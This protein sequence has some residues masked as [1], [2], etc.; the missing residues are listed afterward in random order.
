MSMFSQPIAGPSPAQRRVTAPS[1]PG[2]VPLPDVPGEALELDLAAMSAD[3]EQQIK[4]HEAKLEEAEARM[5]EFKIRNLD[6]QSS[7]GKD[8]MGRVVDAAKQLE[9][10]KLELREAENAR[11]MAKAQISASLQPAPQANNAP[12]APIVES[13]L[14]VATPEIDARIEAQKRKL[15]IADKVAA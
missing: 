10:A 4:Q 7:D 1:A 2:Q 11:D 15:G 3:L 5:K 13:Q 8:A 14:P 12:A 9:Q 6:A